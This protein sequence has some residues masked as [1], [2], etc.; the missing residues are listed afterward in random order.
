MDCGGRVCF[1]DQAGLCVELQSRKGP[2]VIMLHVTEYGTRKIIGDF[3]DD[4]GIELN[5][6][7]HGWFPN[8]FMI[9][10]HGNVIHYHMDGIKYVK[11]CC[12]CEDGLTEGDWIIDCR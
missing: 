1:D 2:E 4:A 8:T 11:D 12:K 5:M 6:A 9:S 3:D 10:D 7:S